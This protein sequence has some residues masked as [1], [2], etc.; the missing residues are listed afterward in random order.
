[1]SNDKMKLFMQCAGFITLFMDS[2]QR[3]PLPQEFVQGL[4][5]DSYLISCNDSEQM[6]NYGPKP[7][8][9]RTFSI[10]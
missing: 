6:Q 5:K 7:Y 1:M 9:L 2:T 10:V 3:K 4:P 8:L